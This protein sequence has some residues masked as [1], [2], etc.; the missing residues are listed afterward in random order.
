M[1]VGGRGEVRL[2]FSY[3]LEDVLILF[4]WYLTDG[5]L[6]A[7]LGTVQFQRLSCALRV[8]CIVEED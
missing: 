4:E 2:R 1:Y 5:K 3:Y 7:M 8:S 6:D